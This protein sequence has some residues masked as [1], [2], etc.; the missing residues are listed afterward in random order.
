[1]DA[2]SI[3]AGGVCLQNTL[4]CL[5]QLI[6]PPQQWDET[7]SAVGCLNFNFKHPSI[8]LKYICERFKKQF[9]IKNEEISCEIAGA[10]SYDFITERTSSPCAP[11]IAQRLNSLATACAR[12][13]GTREG[14]WQ[15][16]A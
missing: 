12:S 10:E 8:I 14:F 9:C 6:Y 4:H 5:L 15:K 13:L 3:I 16:Q 2:P 1:M 7:I 11:P